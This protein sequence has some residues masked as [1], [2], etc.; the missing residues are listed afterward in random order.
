MLDRVRDSAAAQ[1][2]TQKN[3]ATD[4]LGSVARAVR[5]SAEPLRNNQ[6]NTIAQYV[7]KAADQIERFS[8]TL[9]ER[10]V[11]DLVNDA[12]RFARRQPAL[13]IAGA[14]AAGVVGAR[15]LKSSSP[16]RGRGDVE[17]YGN[18]RKV[19]ETRA[20]PGDYRREPRGTGGL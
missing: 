2:S 8:T 13:F 10:E 9:R 3:R 4:G 14:F 18:S 11:G 7:E 20:V 19:G 12:Q 1:L 5:Q 17:H 16:H 15:F 6:Q